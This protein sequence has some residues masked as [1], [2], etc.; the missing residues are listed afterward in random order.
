VTQPGERGRAGHDLV[1]F[2][3]Q[4][5]DKEAAAH[6]RSSGFGVAVTAISAPGLPVHSH[7][8]EA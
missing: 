8:T 3:R 7:L 6:W 2:A 5:K 4:A 1:A